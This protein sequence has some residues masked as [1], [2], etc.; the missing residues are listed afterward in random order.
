MIRF[1]CCI[2]GGSF[3]PQGVKDVPETPLEIILAGYRTALDIGYDFAECTVGLLMKLDETEIKTAASLFQK[4]EFRIEFCNSFIPS[5]NPVTGFDANIGKLRE[6][7]E[8]VM[9]RMSMVG[10][11]TVVFGSGAA[12][13]CPDGF[14]MEKAL[15]QNYEFL[16][17]CG[18]AG[19]KYGITTAV[20]P[21]N[22]SETNIFVTHIDGA[23]MV[24]RCSHPNVKLLSDAYHM[25]RENEDLSVLDTSISEI[26]HIHVAEPPDRKVPGCHG[27][28]FLKEYA[29]KIVSLGYSGTV[30]VEC[31]FDDF[32]IDCAKALKFLQENFN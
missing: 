20:E 3:M 10:A 32:S 28:E 12:R 22:S 13:R 8:K 24:R 18:D 4:G 30:S 19:K 27:G 21:L 1:G 5:S 6:H 9:E 2:P 15:E 29:K 16:M 7:A 23:S 31:G 11:G 14:S 26:V 25:A 17:M